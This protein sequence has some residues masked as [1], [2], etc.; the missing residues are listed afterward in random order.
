[1]P[2]VGRYL[3]GGVRFAGM[4]RFCGVARLMDLLHAPT[5]V[6]VRGLAELTVACGHCWLQ[7]RRDARGR[8]RSFLAMSPWPYERTNNHLYPV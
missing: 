6:L 7:V 2:A 4:R 5:I 1:M 3:G 8:R